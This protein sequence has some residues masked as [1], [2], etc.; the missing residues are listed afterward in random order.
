MV[1]DHVDETEGFSVEAEVA[2]PL[3]E[4]MVLVLHL[5]DQASEEVLHFFL[6]HEHLGDLGVGVLADDVLQLAPQHLLAL[7]MEE[8]ALTL[9]LEAVFADKGWL[10]TL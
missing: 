10:A 6:H 8:G 4:V 9:G 3:L 7:V 1:V 2:D 5:L